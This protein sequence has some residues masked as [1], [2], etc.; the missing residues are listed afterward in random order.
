MSGAKRDMQA[1]ILLVDDEPG[2]LRA[3]ER[4]LRRHGYGVS[5]FSDAT[6]ALLAAREHEFQVV[7]SDYRMP[8]VNG[9]DFLTQLRSQ[10]PDIVRIMLSGEADR[11]A[12]LASI[13]DAGIFRFLAKPWDDQVL[14]DII[15]L[16]V[17]EFQRIREISI[18]LHSH[19]E[20]SDMDYRRRKAVEAL[21]QESPGITEVNW[22]DDDTIVIH[23]DFC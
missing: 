19:R 15:G 6:E 1:K 7:I 8:N 12:V 10:S 18:A 9:V 4:L 21:E 17:A 22:S 23:E 5:K 3:I 13:N 14:L 20:H 2:V 16:A 11:D